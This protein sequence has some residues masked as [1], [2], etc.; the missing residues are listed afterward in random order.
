[1]DFGNTGGAEM[2]RFSIAA[3]AI[4]LL[5]ASCGTTLVSAGATATPL[6]GIDPPPI[7]IPVQEVPPVAP[8]PQGSPQTR[9]PFLYRPA[10]T[11]P[12]GNYG[13]PMNPGPVTGYGPGGMAKPPGA[14]SIPPYH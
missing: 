4:V 13:L 14:P 3:A 12:S 8:P 5:L 7:I 6:A 2:A 9:E 11:A 1:M 10:P